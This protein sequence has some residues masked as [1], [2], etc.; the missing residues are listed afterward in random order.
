MSKYRLEKTQNNMRKGSLEVQIA[1]FTPITELCQQFSPQDVWNITYTVL[2]PEDTITHHGFLLYLTC[3][4]RFGY[5]SYYGNS[6]YSCT[7]EWFMD[8]LWFLFDY[9]ALDVN[10]TVGHLMLDSD[11]IIYPIT[12][13]D[14][15]CYAYPTVPR[16]RPME[17]LFQKGGKSCMSLSW[18]LNFFDLVNP[19]VQDVK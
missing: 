8:Y 7:L 18:M 4:K 3:W 10:M 2:T 9:A 19:N 13:L 16:A 11:R 17:Y 5:Y 12:P 1:R 6:K 14:W 15:L